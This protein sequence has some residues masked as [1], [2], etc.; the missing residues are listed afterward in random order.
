ML[1]DLDYR[2][3]DAVF[4]ATVVMLSVFILSSTIYVV[5]GGKMI[6]SPTVLKFHSTVKKT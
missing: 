5:Q 3:A 4:D 2:P 6:Y 1:L